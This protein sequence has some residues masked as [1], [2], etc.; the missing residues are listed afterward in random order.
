MITTGRKW[1]AAQAV[2]EVKS[3]LRHADIIGTILSWRQGLGF[4]KRA[5]LKTATEK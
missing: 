4:V 2:D 5:A 1:K 3:R